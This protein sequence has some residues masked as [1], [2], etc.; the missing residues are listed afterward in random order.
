M[1]YTIVDD[2][3]GYKTRRLF[4][5]QTEIRVKKYKELRSKSI[6]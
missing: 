1:N 2:K 3:R 4:P 5:S 6:T